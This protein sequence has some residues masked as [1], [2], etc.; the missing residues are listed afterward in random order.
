[1]KG[2]EFSEQT[3]TL[4]KP[5]G[6]KDEDCY[7]LP[8]AQ[9]V[10]ENSDNMDVPCLISC[11]EL[12]DEETAEIIRTKRIYLTITGGI[13]PP[14]GLMAE[15][16]FPDNYDKEQG[17]SRFKAACAEAQARSAISRNSSNQSQ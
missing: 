17:L 9:T 15:N 14:V 6:W 2:V 4:G 5:A 1:M 3:A 8:V 11:W 13:M 10:Y 12:N 7:G 16:P